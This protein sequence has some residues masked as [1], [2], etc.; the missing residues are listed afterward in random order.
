MDNGDT[1]AHWWKTFFS[2]SGIRVLEGHR[3]WDWPEGI[4]AASGLRPVSNMSN[5]TALLNQVGPFRASVSYEQQ[6]YSLLNSKEKQS[7]R[8]IVDEYPYHEKDRTS[9]ECSNSLFKYFINS[10]H[11]NLQHAADQQRWGMP[12]SIGV[13]TEKAS[14]STT[15]KL[16]SI[17]GNANSLLAL[18]NNQ[19]LKTPCNGFS[20]GRNTGFIVERPGVSSNIE[21]R[22]GQ[23]P[24]QSQ[25]LETKVLP[26]FGSNLNGM[27]AEPSKVF[28]SDKLLQKTSN[29]LLASRWTLQNADIA[30]NPTERRGPTQ[31]KHSSHV[32]GAYGTI[33]NYRKD[34]SN[35]N[36]EMTDLNP[37]LLSCFKNP[38]T[39]WQ[40]R[41]IYDNGS[42]SHVREKLHYE[43]HASKS[44]KICF[45]WSRVAGNIEEFD[46]AVSNAQNH[47]NKGKEVECAM[48]GLLGAAKSNIEFSKTFKED[49]S[50]FNI[51]LGKSS[52]NYSP[53]FHEKSLDLYQ[54]SAMIADESYGRDI[55]NNCRK[56]SSLSDI[57]HFNHNHVKP[58]QN[59]INS[60]ETMAMGFTS[61][62]SV[63]VQNASPTLSK[64]K[65][66]G[67]NPGL[68]DEN[69]KMPAV[70]NM[71][72][73]SNRD[74]G[75]ASVRNVQECEIL[76]NPCVLS[77]LTI[78][79][80][81]SK[82]YVHLLDFSRM[83][84]I[85]EVGEKSTS[86]GTI[87]W[88]G[89]NSERFGN[90]TG[91]S[92]YTEDC[93]LPPVEQFFV[94]P[95][96]IECNFTLNKKEQ[97][98]QGLP[99]AYVPEKCSCA[100]QVNCLTGKYDLNCDNCC[101]LAKGD[102]SGTA[103]SLFHSKMNE[104]C[105][106]LKERAKSFEKTENL[107][108]PNIKSV[109]SHSFQWR[110]VPKTI[111]ESCSSTRKEHQAEPFNASLGSPA[112]DVAKC[113]TGFARDVVPLKEPEISNISSGC[114]APD[115][116]QSSIEVNKKDSSNVE[117][118]DIRCVNNLVLDEGSGNDRSW[119]SDDALDNE[120]CPEF[121]GSASKI[122][123][124]KREPLKVVPRKPSLSL[125]EEIRLQNS[126]RSKYAPYQI[127]RSSTFQEESDHL[128]KF[129][130]G[131][132]KRRKTV[133]WMKLD[134][135]FPVSGQSSVINESPKCTEEVGQNA[136]AFWDMQIPVGCDQGSPSNC[137]D[138]VELSF[139]QRNTA[140]SVAKGISIKRDLKRVY[141]H[142]EQQTT[143]A[144]KSS[145]VDNT[146][147]ASEMFRKK[148][149]RL[150]DASAMSKGIREICCNSAELTAKL[151]S[152]GGPSNSLG[153]PNFYKWMAR[154]IVFGKYG[155]IS[156]G[157]P[158][159][160]TK[161]IPLTKILKT[162]VSHAEKSNRNAYDNDKLK[163][164][165]VKVKKT[166]VR[167]VKEMALTK[168]VLKSQVKK[169]GNHDL[170][171]IELETRDPNGEIETASCSATNGS[172]DLSYTLQKCNNHGIADS[173][174]GVQLKTKFKEGRKRSL[175]ELLI[176]GNGFKVA[177]SSVTKNCISLC[178]TT[179][180]CSG[181]L[182]DDAVD[183][184]VQTNEMNNA[185][186]C[187]EKHQPENSDT[188]CC[189][190]GSS[191]KDECN[192]LL[193]CNRFLIK[194]PR[195]EAEAVANED[196][197]FYGRCMLH[198]TSCMFIP[199][200]DSE[201]LQP[202]EK[203]LTCARTEGYKGRKQEGFL[204]NH[205]QD[206]NGNAGC[207]VPQE[208]LNAWLHIHRQ[209]PQRKGH[210]KLSSS[211]VESDCRKAYARY[212]QSK[213]WKHLVVYKSG[214]HALG[215]Y[216]SQFI[217]RGA[218]VVEYV[219]EI[220]GL[221]VA[222]RRESEY[223]SGKKL[224]HKSAC[225]F[226]RIDKEHIIDAT[227]KGG[228]ARFVNHSC[229]P[230]CVAKVIS[231]RNEKKVVFFAER[232]IYPGEEITYDYHFNHEDE[233]EKIPCY[234]NSKNCRRYLN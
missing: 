41:N 228:I 229:Q 96:G 132:K 144:H 232:D 162:A 188:F 73:L 209:K 205:P 115:V 33:T 32:G 234:C 177:N 62:N 51:D 163:S 226:F 7:C 154:P 4:S 64:E 40:F 141:H 91:R 223:H 83:P 81:I 130:V 27:H 80:S 103:T 124:I 190:C 138:S 129:E 182:M 148:R 230:N 218:M 222:D 213:G 110:D 197:S 26:A 206:A 140:F 221:R 46:T 52:S 214:I 112:A 211:N 126:L 37:P 24:E 53:A 99:Y 160:P 198:V 34:S 72:E 30:S 217:S 101:N 56:I 179:S 175:H 9:P 36:L 215:L 15:A 54:M 153:K 79:P 216:T 78:A 168:K 3:G 66:S 55:F 100:V 92:L 109:E 106:F 157:N 186:R 10:S 192:Q 8:N 85:P 149:L 191:D 44:E 166:S 225:Y 22:L 16:D 48:N 12:S 20:V 23:P 21:L 68:Q 187:S 114:S 224:Q 31:L 227:R 75:P 86:P 136:H 74:N 201:S 164:A 39:K 122:N 77:M 57:R 134:A 208:Q 123:L 1:V 142:G 5:N 196:V 202:G 146:L 89:H 17:C 184:R 156:N 183:G 220:V 185:K 118:G 165:S 94:R 35:G 28:F 169:G 69:M 155:I 210:P 212:K 131:S 158:S 111:M 181:E 47:M 152:L 125:I 172:D 108:P 194:G 176:K 116:T 107:V 50:T 95:G 161:I 147:E 11:A 128:Q 119:S 60:K 113:F 18:P 173:K 150:D 127:K 19:D 143:E 133:K 84:K 90:M 105:I 195:S 204:H 42:D 43:S 233:G 170:L 137:A 145:K 139:K 178:Q 45:P 98:S 203:F 200:G 120:L 71:L 76:K 14:H 61:K 102:R 2:K 121:F 104:N 63:F 207:L 87:C 88:M 189:V 174:P 65:C 231:V 199:D 59:S 180:R 193:E 13:N 70:Q 167:H 58:I 93:D 29:E 49:L 219:G 82:D 67:I 151:T 97:C 6:R 38:K 117:G 135:P 25:T 171:P 159:K